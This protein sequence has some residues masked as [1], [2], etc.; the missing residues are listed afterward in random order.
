MTIL[1]PMVCP[2]HVCVVPRYR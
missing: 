2:N 1:V